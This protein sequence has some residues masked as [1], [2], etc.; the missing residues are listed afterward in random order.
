MGALE[1][2]TDCGAEFLGRA[3]NLAIEEICMLVGNR[4]PYAD[5]GCTFTLT[6]TLLPLHVS[7]CFYK[8][9]N[10]PLNK[11]PEGNCSWSGILKNLQPHLMQSH[12]NII[13][14]KN[15]IMSNVSENDMKI[16]L[17]KS[18]IFIYCKYLKGN[19]WFAIVQRVGCSEEAFRCVFKIWSS[20]NKVEFIN[21][22]FPVT[23]IDKNISDVFEE[24]SGMILDNHIIRNFVA[25]SNVSMMAAVEEAK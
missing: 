11:V 18:E 13:S 4:C 14:E 3:R 15:Y 7:K 12:G 21:M 10:C 9:V 1:K 16:M 24:G 25:G 17:H 22:I 19:E 23:N 8:K 20:E 2:C 6:E 5:S